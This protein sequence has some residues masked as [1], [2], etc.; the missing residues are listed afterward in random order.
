MKFINHNCDNSNSFLVAF[1][2]A[3]TKMHV[4]VSKR[5]KNYSLTSN[6]IDVLSFLHENYEL[7]TA[8]DIVEFIGVSKGLVSRSVDSLI[9]RGYLIYEPDIKDK[10]K[11]RLF[12][13][14]EGQVVVQEIIKYDR[15]FFNMVTKGITA[16]E[17][18]VHVS[19][20]KKIQ[21]NLKNIDQ[22]IKD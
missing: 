20:M 12:I 7:N 2:R 22:H 21:E 14:D 11:Q 17:M 9:E 10:R 19:I 8:K 13:T 15:E 1:K 16:K 18:Q 4:F 3:R 6:Q 5:I